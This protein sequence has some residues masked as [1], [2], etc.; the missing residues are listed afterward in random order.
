[1][2]ILVKFIEACSTKDFD[3][4]V[5]SFKSYSDYVNLSR[6]LS[7]STLKSTQLD[8]HLDELKNLACAK[9]KLLVLVDLGGTLFFRSK[10]KQVKGASFNFKLHQ[11]MYFLRPGHKE[12]LLKLFAHPRIKLAFYS[13]IMFKNIW[14]VM[15]RVL[16]DDLLPI[17][18]T[19]MVFD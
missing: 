3:Q 8:S 5:D 15:E 16:I 14:P 19:F 13:S 6:S 12:F 1:L 11:Y 2:P 10:D 4:V 9:F 17:K 18:E 7:T